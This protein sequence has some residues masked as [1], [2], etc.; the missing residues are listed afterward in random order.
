MKL[1]K[2]AIWFGT[3]EEAEE[4]DRLYW[5]AK[6]PEERRAYLIELV[7]LQ[8]IYGPEVEEEIVAMI[9]REDITDKLVMDQRIWEMTEH[10]RPKRG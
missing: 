3:I 1:D 9:E 2:T 7:R 8:P 10:L 6:S 4:K 5:E